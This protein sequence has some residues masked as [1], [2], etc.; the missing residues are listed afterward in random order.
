MKLK[1]I[2]LFVWVAVSLETTVQAQNFYKD[3]TPRDRQ[4]TI[5]IG[6][7]VA[8]T[9]FSFEESRYPSIV[10]PSLFMAYGQQFKDH[11]FLVT[12]VGVQLSESNHVFRGSEDLAPFVDQGQSITYKTQSLFADIMPQFNI[13][14]SDTHVWR[15][16]FQVYGGIGLGI[17]ASSGV[18]QFI[19]LK[20]GRTEFVGENDIN[21]EYP[22]MN[23]AT[24][25]IPMRVGI[26]KKIHPHW[27]L[28]LQGTYMYLF[29]NKFDGNNIINNRNDQLYQI[30]LTLKR[31]LPPTFAPFICY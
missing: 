29:T 9:D 22:R 11:I 31:Y 28:G 25:Y 5:G 27:D 13:W 21:R 8:Y 24:G 30:H 10:H 3:L 26:S 4:L 6:P 20:E 18:E 15:P 12:T 14:R 7:A 17:I 19:G 2:L 16:R 1:L 23:R